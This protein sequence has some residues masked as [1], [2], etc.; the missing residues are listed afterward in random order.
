[1]AALSDMTRHELECELLRAE[2]DARRA[3]NNSHAFSLRSELARTQ[4][5]KADAEGC[6]R[7]WKQ[8][9]EFADLRVTDI[10]REIS[11]RQA[12]TL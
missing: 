5:A 9:A 10:E 4:D 6:L 2:H 11:T 7:Y 12:L 8:Q 3:H 1:M